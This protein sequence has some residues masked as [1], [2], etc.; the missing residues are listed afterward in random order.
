MANSEL[1]SLVQSQF[2]A[3]AEHYATSRIH[4]EGESLKRLVE[5]IEPRAE[6]RA[7][8]VATGTGHTA[9]ALAPLVAEVIATDM[10]PRMLEV[11]AG[12]AQKRGI[13]NIAFQ[14]AEAE[15]LPFADASFDL[16]TCRIAPHHFADVPR[17]VTEVKRVLKPQ[18]IFG[19][20]DNIG[21]DSLK[22]SAQLDIIEKTRDPSHARLLSAGEWLQLLRGNGFVVRHSE[23]LDKDM[24]LDGWAD[25]MSAS[26]EVKKKL[27]TMLRDP[28][29][30][31][32]AYLRTRDGADGNL[33]FN[34]LEAVFVARRTA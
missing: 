20:V 26:A 9:M 11:A 33:R 10:T 3:N 27:A 14:E 7:L 5:L 25:R 30:E 32:Q 16:V 2:A 19:L 13:K 24:D 21:P 18:G 23:V 31:L 15:K 17:F 12:L 8:D 28:M 29:P 6:W 22:A 34:L 1:K 4:A